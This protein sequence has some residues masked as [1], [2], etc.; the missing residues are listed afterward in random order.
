[1][2][3][4]HEIVDFI[5]EYLWYLV[6][7]VLVFAGLLLTGWSK[8]V[9][10]RLIG[11]MFRVITEKPLIMENGKKGISSF[12]AFTISAASRVGTGNIAGVAIAITL[13]GPGAIFWMWLM[14]IVGSATAF[15]ESTLGQLYKVQDKDSYRGGPA[16]YMTQGLNAKWMGVLFAVIIT[17]TYGLVF[18]SVQ[19]NSIA[20]SVST[21][22][23]NDSD[24]VFITVGVVVAV[25]TALVIFGGIRR[26][27]AVT[28]VLVPAMALSYIGLGLLVV[29]MNISEVPAMFRLVFES[30]FG[31]RE[32]AGG[33]VG[34]AIMW[35][36]RRGLFSNEAGMG[37]VPNAAS[38]A[39]VSHPVKQGLVQAL[40]V[41]FDTLIICSMTA[42]IILL[43]DPAFG[44]REGAA[45]TQN[46]LS[47]QFGEWAVQYL[48]V[49]IFILA[50]S[51]VLGNYYYGE[52]NV[53]F[54]TQSKT[55]LQSFRLAVVLCVFLGSI[56]SLSLVWDLADMTMGVMALLNLAAVIPLSA[57]A[58]RLLKHYLAQRRE[59]FN[60]VFT[61]DDMPDLKG[62]ECWDP[63]APELQ[64]ARKQ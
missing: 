16:Y 39:A 1:M 47:L 32:A 46:A 62:V 17:V 50:F 27:G 48:A 43:A 13:G 11:E 2:D 25:L 8:F 55:V 60:P 61:R 28:Q 12:K 24:T 41:Y 9:Q 29:V 10:L 30:A 56:G 64:H 44:E 58:M 49:V 52:A 14:A 6:I 63:T 31:L 37:S 53:E 7:G 51:S 57:I 26:I 20:D 23:D 22:L 54:L 38:T 4:V 3:A 36:I 45:L 15:V 19:A 35:G 34:A 5:N 42:F 21:A 40:G 33:T 18:N 59:G